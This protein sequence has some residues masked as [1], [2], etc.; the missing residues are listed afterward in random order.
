MDVPRPVVREI[1]RL[2]VDIRDQAMLGMLDVAT[3]REVQFL[4]KRLESVRQLALMALVELESLQNT[5]RFA[6]GLTGSQDGSDEMEDLKR[7]MCGN[8]VMATTIRLNPSTTSTRTSVEGMES[9]H[10]TSYI[11]ADDEF[12]EESA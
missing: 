3:E 5:A 10:V 9:A 4:R 12:N 2:C 7:G 8:C 1:G 11:P 6:G